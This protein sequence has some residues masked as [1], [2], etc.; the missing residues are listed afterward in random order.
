MTIGSELSCPQHHSLSSFNGIA[1][2]IQTAQYL[3]ELE[4]LHNDS[5][6]RFLHTAQAVE[7]EWR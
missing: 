5:P 3:A 1:I 6:V 4:R 7:I 2:D